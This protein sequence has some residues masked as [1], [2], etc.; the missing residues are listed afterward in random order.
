[1]NSTKLNIVFRRCFIPIGKIVEKIGLFTL[2]SQREKKKPETKKFR[3]LNNNKEPT[4][5]ILSY[6]Y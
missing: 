4:L 5:F 3:A 2:I 6:F 1:M